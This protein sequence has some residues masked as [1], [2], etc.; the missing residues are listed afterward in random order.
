MSVLAWL[1]VSAISGA[2][3][4]P[5]QFTVETAHAAWVFGA[6]AIT[7]QFNDKAAGTNYALP[8]AASVPFAR[9]LKDGAW[10]P[11][12]SANLENGRLVVGFGPAEVEAVLR[13]QPGPDYFVVD[14]L[15]L[16]GEGVTE[17]VFFDVPLTLKG[18]LDEPFACSLLALN[19]QTDSPGI[20]GPNGRLEAHAFRRFGFQGARAAIVACPMARLRGVLKDIVASAGPDIP[21]SNIGGP[22]ALDAESN[23]G[24]YLIDFGTLTEDT[25]DQWIATAR[26]LGL[27]QIDFHTGTSLR[28]GDYVP[29][30]KLFPRGR[31]SVKAVT[32]KLHN[33]G[34]SAGLHT[35]AFFIAKDSPYVTPLPDPRLGKD[36]SFTLSQDLPAEAVDVP[37]AES[38]GNMTTTTGFFVWNSVTLQIDDELIVYKQVKKEAPFAFVEC[39]RGAHGTRVATHAKGAPVHHLRECFG[40]FTPDADST[41]LAEVAANTAEVFNA[42]GFDMIYL[43]ALDGEGVLA[44]PEWGWHYGSKFV[45][46]IA[47]RL[48]KPALFEMS[49]FHHHLWYVRARMGAWDAS[50]RAHSRNVDVHLAANQQAANMLLPMNLGWWT[51]K[52]WEDGPWVT[53]IDPTFPEDVEYLMGKCLG[54]DM[55]FSLMGINPE[56]FATTPAYQ[57]L[58]PIFMEYEAL[59]HANSVPDRIKARLRAPGESFAMIKNSGAGRGFAPADTMKHKVSGTGD[60]SAKWTVQNRFGA[61][62]LRVRIEALMM[63]EPFDAP[64]GV[65]AEDFQAGGLDAAAVEGV[66]AGFVPEPSPAGA[67]EGSGPWLRYTAANQRDGAAGAWSKLERTYPAPKD[68]SGTMGLGVWVKG[69]GGGALLNV[70]LRSPEHT[71]Y[72]G[73]GDH[74]ITLDFTGW[75]YFELVEPDSDRIDD[76]QWPYGGVHA[77]YREF[78]DYAQVSSMTLWLNNL[79]PGKE[80]ACVIGAVHALPLAKGKVVRPSLNVGGS[81]VTFPVELETGQYLEW[82]TAGPAIVYGPKGERIAEIEPEGERADLAPGE[83]PV[84][85]S[86]ETEGNLRPR[87]RVTVFT[88]GDALLPGAWA[89]DTEIAP[90]G[91]AA[92]GKS[93]W[94]RFSEQNEQAGCPHHKDLCLLYVCRIGQELT[95]ATGC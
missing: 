47:K 61:Q 71:V 64:G 17:I 73:S 8:A 16:E 81:A 89:P 83:T 46:E 82:D 79:P 21:Q 36:A 33:A 92:R 67:P 53:Q 31:E 48:D 62:A 57:R 45:F 11:A 28:F 87:V 50:L 63:V 75:R 76:Y 15:S 10:C 65:L 59:R 77:T 91:L 51:V 44:G 66:T 60:G 93:S 52:T 49:T 54:A 26:S 2:P 37:V 5:A 3:G 40:L 18:T 43:D 39:E 58:A 72:R 14:V 27:N 25:V 30:P 22:W 88:Q 34:I 12:T 95:F 23:R 19:L 85:F 56:N 78:V 29:N 84:V 41:L 69:D 68:W 35:Y 42:C 24:S 1:I 80:T 55:G 13:V 32:D 90:L 20:P 94:R 6:D 74:Y 7:R 38:T 4:V 70:Q 86:S 9:V